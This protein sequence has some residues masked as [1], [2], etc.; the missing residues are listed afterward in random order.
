MIP[1]ASAHIRMPTQK[2]AKPGPGSLNRPRPRSRPAQTT[3]P[4]MT[5]QNSPPQSS[6]FRI[7][8]GPG[9]AARSRLFLPGETDA[10]ERGLLARDELLDG[11]AVADRVHVARHHVVPG[12]HV[13]DRL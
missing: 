13:D 4:P 12:H 9:C 6:E 10:L 1:S 5:S 11:L 7:I 3:N 2:N 8:G